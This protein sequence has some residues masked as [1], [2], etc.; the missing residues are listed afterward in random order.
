MEIHSTVNL[1]P[2]VPEQGVRTTVCDPRVGRGVTSCPS[3]SRIT[4]SLTRSC[5]P[6]EVSGVPSHEILLPYE[7]RRHLRRLVNTP[8][9]PMGALSIPGQEEQRA[10]IVRQRGVVRLVSGRTSDVSLN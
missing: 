5:R 2:E 4:V 10:T 6:T 3:P 7:R 8:S 9:T 1:G